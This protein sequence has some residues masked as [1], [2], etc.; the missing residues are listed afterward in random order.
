[1]LCQLYVFL[2][3]CRDVTWLVYF[4]KLLCSNVV[5]Q[6]MMPCDY[7]FWCLIFHTLLQDKYFT[8]VLLKY[9]FIRIKVYNCSKYY[10]LIQIIQRILFFSPWNW[11][12]CH[13]DYLKCVMKWNKSDKSSNRSRHHGSCCNDGSNAERQIHCSSSL[14]QNGKGSK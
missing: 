3:L 12:F 1:M 4:K 5:S 7:V 14:H 2:T 6:F 11:I 9:F 13:C 10:Q 8:L